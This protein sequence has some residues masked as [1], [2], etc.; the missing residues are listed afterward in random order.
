MKSRPISDLH[1]ISVRLLVIC[2]LFL[3]YQN[4]I[5]LKPHTGVF[6]P[7][8]SPEFVLKFDWSCSIFSNDPGRT[9][10]T[11]ETHELSCTFVFFSI[12]SMPFHLCI[13]YI[14]IYVFIFLYRDPR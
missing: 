1:L 5:K 9:E 14:F 8:K 2:V 13:Y 3:V 10:H 6:K 11:H 7:Q 12:K 4:T